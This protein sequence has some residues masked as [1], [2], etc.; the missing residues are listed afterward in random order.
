MVKGNITDLKADIIVNASNGIGYMG[1]TIGR[2]FQLNGVAESIHY[3]TEGKVEKEAK[4]AAKK[5]KYLPRFLCGHKP[6]EIF[7]TGAGNLNASYIV[8]AVTMHYPG[9]SANI[10]IVKILLPKILFKSRELNAKSL[11]LPLLGTGTGRIPKNEI[12][13][14]YEDF[15]TD[16]N[17]IDIIVSYI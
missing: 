6:G 8:H 10:D 4:I 7:I 11:V 2:F 12:I 14:L 9:M 5:N 1:G 3:V 13:K 15:F 17:D 16:I